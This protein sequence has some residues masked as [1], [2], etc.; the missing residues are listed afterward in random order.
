MIESISKERFF[1]TLLFFIFTLLFFGVP[2]LKF[3]QYGQLPDLLIFAESFQSA[4]GG[5]LFTNHHHYW[6]QMSSLGEQ[7]QPDTKAS[8]FGMHF[9]PFLFLVLPF[10]IIFPSVYTLLL[11]QACA[12]ASAL[13][14]LYW[15]TRKILHSEKLAL[16][17]SLCF[18]CHP[19]SLGATTSFFPSY[20]WRECSDR[21]SATWP[22]RWPLP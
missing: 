9:R 18:L 10:Y 15:M 8:M 6:Q 11:F 12:V 17:C 3:A 22:G 21:S 13:F 19:L 7:L 5:E 2:S 4:A 20:I 16:L 14:P 1:L